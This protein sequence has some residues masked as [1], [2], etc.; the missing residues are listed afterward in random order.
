MILQALQS[1]SKNLEQKFVAMNTIDASNSGM[2]RII[3]V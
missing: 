1:N 3:G 2:T